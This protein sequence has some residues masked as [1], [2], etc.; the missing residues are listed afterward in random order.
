MYKKLYDQ[1]CAPCLQVPGKTPLR[2]DRPESTCCGR[3]ALHA[4]TQHMQDH[5]SRAVQHAIR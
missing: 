2:Q 1:C 5:V 4:Q 3:T